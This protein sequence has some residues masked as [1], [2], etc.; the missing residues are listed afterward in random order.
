MKYN[1]S[2][3]FFL[4]TVKNKYSYNFKFLGVPIIQYPQDIIKV[5]ELI[6][7][8]KPD[9][10]IETGIAKGG[11]LILSASILKLLDIKLQ[12]KKSLVIGIDIKIKNNNKHKIKSHF[13]KNKIKLIEGSS[14]DKKLVKIIKNKA[15]NFKKVMIFLDSN[16]SHSHVLEELRLYSGLVSKG[17]YIVVF[18]TA[19][20]FLPKKKYN[21]FN[22]RDWHPGNSPMTAINSFLKENK[23]FKIDTKIDKQLVIS[24]AENGYLKKTK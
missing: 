8:I 15:K 18:D 7:K 11:S 2:K 6:W 1:Y 12:R 22:N 13:L 16:H 10:V 5:Q 4:E 9:L 20:E 14:I 17:S 24:V 3:K 19:I 23:N 21:F